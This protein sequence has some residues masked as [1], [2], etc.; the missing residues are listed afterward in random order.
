MYPPLENSTTRI[1]IGHMARVFLSVFDG[2]KS[3]LKSE[4][5]DLRGAYVS[6]A[7]S[8]VKLAVKL[9]VLVSRD[10][11]FLRDQRRFVTDA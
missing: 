3:R 7:H 8:L 2:I 10:S 9:S 1:T 6:P 11:W 5:P 4:V